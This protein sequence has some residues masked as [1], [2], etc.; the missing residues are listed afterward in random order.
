[1]PVVVTFDA[2]NMPTVAEAFRGVYYD[3]QMIFCG[4]DDQENSSNAGREKAEAAAKLVNG[5]TVFPD[6]SCAQEAAE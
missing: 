1:L 6:F 5:V 4:D 2:G 3:S